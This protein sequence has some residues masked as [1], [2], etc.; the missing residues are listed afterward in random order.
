[1][2]Y[3]CGVDFRRAWS[4]RTGRGMEVGVGEAVVEGETE[5]EMRER[6][7]GESVANRV[8]LGRTSW[9]TIGGLCSL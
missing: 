5:P 3:D 6:V 2:K 1:M 8:D 9:W 4:G 7:E